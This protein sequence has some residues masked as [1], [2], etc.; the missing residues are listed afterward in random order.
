MKRQA[1]L[2]IRGLRPPRP[3]GIRAWAVG[4][5]SSHYTA[6]IAADTDGEA[7]AMHWKALRNAGWMPAFPAIKSR[8]LPEWDEWAALSPV[9][10]RPLV[11]INN[12]A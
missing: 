11:P 6:I 3:V 12:P 9:R 5:G 8:R 7:R 1:L 2:P 4:W 10:F